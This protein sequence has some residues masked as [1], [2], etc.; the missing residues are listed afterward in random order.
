MT[1]SIF[2]YWVSEDHIQE[3]YFSEGFKASYSKW[4]FTILGVLYLIGVLKKEI[5]L[6]GG[7]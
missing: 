2:P 3:L 1:S 5:L 4:G 6:F 7:Q